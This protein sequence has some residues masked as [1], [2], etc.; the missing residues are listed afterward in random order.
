[1]TGKFATD[2]NYYA[3]YTS[4]KFNFSQGT[5]H[6]QVL[7][8][9]ITAQMVSSSYSN[10]YSW[11]AFSINSSSN[12]I[13][14]GL[15]TGNDVYLTGAKVNILMVT[16]NSSTNNYVPVVYSSTSQEGNVLNRRFGYNFG[17]NAS[18]FGYESSGYCLQGLTII[19]LSYY[20][21]QTSF[22]S[23]LFSYSGSQV[24]DISTSSAWGVLL[25]TRCYGFCPYV[26]SLPNDWCSCPIRQFAG[27]S[28]C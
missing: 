17:I 27:S 1:M 19:D 8:E 22:S 9:W 23:F 10:Y 2:T 24:S 3:N 26:P 12:T 13:K 11:S 20:S 14:I 4:T 16:R 15:S 5:P 6:I 25:T 18:T 21:D 7:Y 28:S